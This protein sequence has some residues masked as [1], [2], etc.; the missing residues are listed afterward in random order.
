ASKSS[1]IKSS[2]ISP[3]SSAF[4]PASSSSNTNINS[5]STLSFSN[6]SRKKSRSS[7]F[8]KLSPSKNTSSNSNASSQSQT[9][10]SDSSHDQEPDTLL[11]ACNQEDQILSSSSITQRR[12]SIA[13]IWNSAKTPKSPSKS[14]SLEIMSEK[15]R[16]ENKMSHSAP[17]ELRKSTSLENT[18]N[19]IPVGNAS[20]KSYRGMNRVDHLGK[21]LVGLKK[22]SHSPSNREPGR[23][24]KTRKSRS[25]VTSPEPIMSDT[26]EKSKSERNGDA[27]NHLKKK[28][29]Q[30]HITEYYTIKKEKSLYKVIRTLPDDPP[31][32]R[33]SCNKSG[34]AAEESKRTSKNASCT[35]TTRRSRHITDA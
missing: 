20:R 16:G 23:S 7:S 13:D 30:K 32:E 11:D 31:S 34:W 22:R 1:E 6:N 2:E 9:S 18:R 26:S 3:P 17:P 35:I 24:L 15:F 10:P 27:G 28:S 25:R 14:R 5:D 29:S 21:K 33:S 19:K 12:D 8:G 4:T